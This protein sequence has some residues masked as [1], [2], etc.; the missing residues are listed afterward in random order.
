MTYH[1]AHVSRLLKHLNWTPQKPI[2][3]AS[4]RDEA[5]IA[6]WRQEVWHE[7]KKKARLEH[8]TLVF[9][10]ESGFYLLPAIVRT[11]APCGVTPVLRVYL[12]RDHLSTMGAITM[13]GDLLTLTRATT[14][15][16]VESTRFLKHLQRQLGPRL[17]VIWDGSPIHRG[18]P[19]KEFLADGGA[20][21]VHLEA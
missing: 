19:V 16:S 9:V 6:T 5:K 1:P 8:R 20:P 2:E 12:T 17:L 3:R 11:Y 10:N 15:T 4:Q 21:K 7:L 18:A 13:A 14:I